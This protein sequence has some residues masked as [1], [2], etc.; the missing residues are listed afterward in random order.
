MKVFVLLLILS[1]C[2]GGT[3][4]AAQAQPSCP[5]FDTTPKQIADAVL[6]DAYN[7]QVHRIRSLYAS[8][9]VSGQTRKDQV[10]GKH[11]EELPG[12]IDMVKPDLV[13][14]RGVLR[15]NSSRGFEMTSD[16]HEFSLLVPE[17]NKKVFLVGP[18][19]APAK[20]KIPRENLRP[21]PFL[22]ALRWQEGKLRAAPGAASPETRTLEIELPPTRNGA[23]T[24]KVEFDLRGGVVNSLAAY[25]DAGQLIYEARYRD[26]KELKT[27]SEKGPEGCFPRDIHLTRP[28]DDYE[29]NLRITQ[30]ALNP[31]IPMSTF[32]PS[33]PHGIPVMHVDMQ[34]NTSGR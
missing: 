23:R 17:D 29:L 24:A 15:L 21:Q 28:E 19:D 6:L 8:A 2:L 9:M 11:A 33:P 13:R 32:R 10:A 25:S 26:W 1:G 30:I 7:A 34:G 3:R 14:I 5:L 27:A 12:I 16:G 18:S 4:L 22:D 20:S 31:D